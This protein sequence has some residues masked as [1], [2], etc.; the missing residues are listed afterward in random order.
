MTD[1]TLELDRLQQ[2]YKTAVD[3]WVVGIRNEEAL[4]L[5][6]H[7]VA[8]VDQWEQAHFQEDTLRERV[9]LA[10]KEY[11]DALRAKFFGF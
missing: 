2:A 8:Q 7:S 4:A 6:N 3:E 5:V 9:I 1:E 11:E 10:K